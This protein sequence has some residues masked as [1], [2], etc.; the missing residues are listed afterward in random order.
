MELKSVTIEIPEGC[1][2]ILGQTHFIKTVEDLYEI[3]VGTSSQVKFGIAFCEASG[4]CLIRIVGN[5]RFL[6]DV[7]TKNAQAV[8]AGH[9]FIILLKEAYPINFLN[10]IKQCPEVCTIY[11]ATANPVQVIVAETDQGRGILGLI[12]GFSPKGVEAT[13]DVQARQQFLRQIGYKL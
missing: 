3:M 9:S 11:C 6:Q 8:A 1:N 4:P 12:D 2:L 5:D 13:E 7:A 10:A